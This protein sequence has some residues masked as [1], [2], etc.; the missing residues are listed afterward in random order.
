V[1]VGVYSDYSYSRTGEVLHAEE[2]FALFAAGLAQH[3]EYLVLIGRLD[4]TGSGRHPYPL[5]G[6]GFVALPHYATLSRPLD[7]ARMTISTLRRF[8]RALGELDAVWLLGPHPFAIVFA[9]LAAARRKHVVL[10]TRQDFPAY[11]RSRHPGR[12]SLH[13]AAIVLEAAWR[14]LA[15]R[16]PVVV[17]GPELARKYARSPQ[18]LVTFVSLVREAALNEATEISDRQ[19]DGNLGL[20]SVG[21]L[22]AEKNPLLLADAL[23]ELR[24]RDARWHLVVCGSGSMETALARRLDELGVAADAELRGYVPF[25]KLGDVYRTSHAFLHV[26]WTEGFPQVIIEA[27]AAGLPVV[28]TDVGGIAETVGEAVLLIPPGD[29]SAAAAAV[30]RLADD[31]LLRARLVDAGMRCARNWTLEAETG[32]VAAFV[33]RDAPPGSL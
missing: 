13:L 17:V 26:S 21:R 18:V 20:L 16:R 11:V 4:E 28:A 5:P 10:G 19:Y 1:R 14:L 29:A 33:V 9:A 30:A 6:V 24:T 22:D 27:F 3:L 8:W 15:L 7:A 23:A 31:P 25:D 2:A 32:R 12:R